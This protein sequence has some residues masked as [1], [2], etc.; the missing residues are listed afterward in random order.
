MFNRARTQVSEEHRR[1]HGFTLIEVLL[2]IA[3]LAAIAGMVVPDLMARQTK[4]QNDTAMMTVRST[5]NAVKMYQIDHSGRLP[6]QGNEI[7][8]LLERPSDDAQWFGPYLGRNP[9]DPWGNM[10]QCRLEAG[11]LIIFSCGQDGKPGT[12]D[13][14]FDPEA[15][16]GSGS[17]G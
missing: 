17:N 12:E 6:T 2:V 11:Q 15:R 16:L 1:N 8:V 13:D 10:L 5:V 9:M 3:I 4:A 7:A 14:V